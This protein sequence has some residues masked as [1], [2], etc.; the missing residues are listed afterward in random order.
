[1]KRLRIPI[2]R[3]NSWTD[4][5]RL[6][7]RQN[8]LDVELVPDAGLLP[9]TAKG[10]AGDGWMQVFT[11]PLEEPVLG[12]TFRDES[13]LDVVFVSASCSHTAESRTFHPHPVNGRILSNTS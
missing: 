4:V 12:Y 11:K 8:S 2:D 1:M 5:A 3:T 7:Q 10:K 6:G 13:N 9:E